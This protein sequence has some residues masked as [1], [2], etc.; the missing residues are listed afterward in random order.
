MKKKVEVFF[1]Y[2]CPYCDEG[3]RQFLK[4]L[5][6]YK[7]VQVIW[8]PCESHPRPEYATIHS[9]CAIQAMYVLREQN[10]DLI[11]FHLQVFDAY[12]RQNRRIDDPSLLAS[13]VGNCGGNKTEAARAL[14][15]NRYAA[16]VLEGNRYAW[17]EKQLYAV[18]SYVCGEKS[19]LSRDGILVPISKV[20]ALLAN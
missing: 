8:R 4:I 7:D 12:F 6:N 2:I 13:L 5:P 9:D 14:R 11:K 17:E 20:Q 1:D 19:A 10:G 15:E 3:I 16:E 18:P